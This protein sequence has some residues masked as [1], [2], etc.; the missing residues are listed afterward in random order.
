LDHE[1]KNPLTAIRA[2]LAN[3]AGVGS[4]E[5]RQEALSSVNTQALRL[6]RLAADMRKLADIETRPLE[7]T[8]LN[9]TDLLQ[10]VL[11]V[12]QEICYKWF[13]TSRRTAPKP[14]HASSR[15]A[16]PRHPGPC[17]RCRGIPICCS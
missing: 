1:L 10:E 8:S 6:S 4:E 14:L 16:C 12:A 9:L 11:D 3:V 13:S 17:R 7:R 15:L 5:A 2:A